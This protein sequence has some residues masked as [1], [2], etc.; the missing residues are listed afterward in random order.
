MPRL[1]CREIHF[2]K[3][4][5]PSQ[6]DFLIEKVKEAVAE[7]QVPTDYDVRIYKNVFTCCGIG[8]LGVIVEVTGPEKEQLKAIDLRA[9]SRVLE[10]CE[11]EGLDVGHHSYGQYET[12]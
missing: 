12:V 9:M 6:I 7:M 10:F 8:G 3:A 4:T 5:N 1:G 11:K 2:I